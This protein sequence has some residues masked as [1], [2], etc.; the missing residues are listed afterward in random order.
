MEYS[1]EKRDKGTVISLSGDVTES[2]N[3]ELK[4]TLQNIMNEGETSI[5]VD[6]GKVKHMNASGLSMLLSYFLLAEKQK[7]TFRIANATKTIR[8]LLNIT[9]LSKIIPNFDSVEKALN[10]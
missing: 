5:V 6:L 7:K 10:H 9:K 1:V 8:T 2:Q 4:K 3:N